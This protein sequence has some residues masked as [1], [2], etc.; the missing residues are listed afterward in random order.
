MAKYLELKRQ[1][2]EVAIPGTIALWVMTGLVQFS[3]V[4]IGIIFKEFHDVR[5]FSKM[6]ALAIILSTFGVCYFLFSYKD[7]T[8]AILKYFKQE[9]FQKSNKKILFE[10][11][12]WLFFA[13]GLFSLPLLL[14]IEMYK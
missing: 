12:F 11:A 10:I 2:E 7:Q 14:F 3:F 13:F 8:Q 6:G 4:S 5:S 9:G 1:A